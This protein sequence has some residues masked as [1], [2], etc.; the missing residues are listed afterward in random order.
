[1]APVVSSDEDSVN[2]SPCSHCPVHLAIASGAS[3]SRGGSGF[4]GWAG[5]MKPRLRK[6]QL[7]GTQFHS[8]SPLPTAREQDSKPS[9]TPEAPSLAPSQP[10]QPPPPPFYVTAVR[11][12]VQMSFSTRRA[13]ADSFCRL[14]AVTAAASLLCIPCSA[15]T[16]F[17]LCQ[18]VY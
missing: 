6:D 11:N 8:Q 2:A 4:P 3:F 12:E 16:S 17:C 13:P 10:Q 15:Q 9:F 1:M 7:L 18:G 14:A 5:L